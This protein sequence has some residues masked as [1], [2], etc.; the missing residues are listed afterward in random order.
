MDINSEQRLIEY[1]ICFR[2]KY[3][4]EVNRLPANIFL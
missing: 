3:S 2:A 4:F 1:D